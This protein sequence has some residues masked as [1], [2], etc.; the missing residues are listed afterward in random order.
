MENALQKEFEYYLT[1][2]GELVEQYDG[3]FVVIKDCTVIGAYDDQLV[4]IA[5]TQKSHALGSFLVQKV[6]PG[7]EADTQMFHS[8]VVFATE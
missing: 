4:A 5:E 1:H 3:K 8:R 7:D 2:K 6:E